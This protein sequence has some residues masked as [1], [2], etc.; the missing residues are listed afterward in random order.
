[1]HA[2]SIT[3]SSNKI[4]S[5][6]QGSVESLFKEIQILQSS[7]TD[8]HDADSLGAVEIAL[9]KRATKLADIISAIKIQEALNNNKLNEAE[10][11]LLKSHPG[12]MKNMGRRTVT[13][14]MLG[15][16]LVTIEVTYYHQ[17]SDTKSRSGKGFYPKLL[18]LGIHEK[19]TPALSSRVSLFATAACSFEI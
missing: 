6:L 5:N 8:I 18:L 14:R 2:R 4:I 1:M 10:K 16:T 19:C 9:H 13:I 11:D 7:A 12:K 3:P 17:K 15:G